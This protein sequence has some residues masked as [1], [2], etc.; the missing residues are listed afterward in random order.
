I[1]F[2]LLLGVSLGLAAPSEIQEVKLERGGCP[3]FW[4]SYN[5]HCYKYVATHTNWADAELQCVSQGANLVSI[6]SVEE[7][8]FVKN[9]IKNFDHKQGETWIGLS[10]IHKEQYWMWS[11]GWPLRFQLWNSGEPN[12]VAGNEHCVVINWSA[13]KNWNDFRCSENAPSVCA[14]RKPVC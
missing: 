14:T 11:D 8:N 9:L 10:D 7:N 5:G 2:L 1:V 6:H 12:N 3:M 4:Y 13:E